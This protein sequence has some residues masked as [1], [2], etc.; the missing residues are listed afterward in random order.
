MKIARE[1]GEEI[2]SFAVDRSRAAFAL[3]VEPIIAEKL[4]N[5]KELLERIKLDVVCE[6]VPLKTDGEYDKE[7]SPKM[8]LSSIGEKAIAALAMFED[9]D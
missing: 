9:A 2:A 4:R 3:E 1:L 8:A 6:G 5:V 7:C